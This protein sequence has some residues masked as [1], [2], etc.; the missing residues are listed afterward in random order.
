MFVCVFIFDGGFKNHFPQ[1]LRGTKDSISFKCI[2]EYVARVQ[3]ESFD[4]I[5]KSQL[6]NSTELMSHCS[7]QIRS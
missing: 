5:I 3:N 1:S 7:R 2:T 4:L 6:I